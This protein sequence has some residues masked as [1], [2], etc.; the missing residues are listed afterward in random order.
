M[1]A[2]SVIRKANQIAANFGLHPL[3]EAAAEVAG[4]IRTYWPVALQ[5]EL[6]ELAEAGSSEL[7]PIAIAAAKT[8]R[9]G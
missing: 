6:V 3:D 7:T 1:P 5:R 4:H 2:S 8:L 9:D